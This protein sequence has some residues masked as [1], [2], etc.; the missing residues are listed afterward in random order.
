MALWL[1]RI[2]LIENF[3]GTAVNIHI[4][5]LHHYLISRW[6]QLLRGLQKQIHTGFK[7]MQKYSLIFV[8]ENRNTKTTGFS[9][10]IVARHTHD[11][12][13]FV[14]W[15]Q[16][17]PKTLPTTKAHIFE[18]III[19]SQQQL[20]CKVLSFVSVCPRCLVHAFWTRVT[21]ARLFDNKCRKSLYINTVSFPMKTKRMVTE[22]TFHT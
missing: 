9:N 12:I 18:C 11:C 4:S 13:T 21:V 2:H 15:K 17:Q 7:N 16:K 19:A 10:Q 8:K 6:Y 1:G 22:D 5:Q 14:L 3:L 20:L